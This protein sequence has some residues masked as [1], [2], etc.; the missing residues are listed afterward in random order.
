MA[1][2]RR[3]DPYIRY[4]PYSERHIRILSTLLKGFPPLPVSKG[5]LVLILLLLT[6]YFRVKHR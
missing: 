1:S 5:T 2:A 3:V 6:I 4:P